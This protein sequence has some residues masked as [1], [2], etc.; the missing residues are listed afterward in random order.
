MVFHLGLLVM[1]PASQEILVPIVTNTTTTGVGVRFYYF[2]A[3]YT[4]NDRNGLQTSGMA[5]KLNGLATNGYI[6]TSSFVQAATNVNPQPIFTCPSDANYCEFKNITYIS[7]S[8][9][10]ENITENDTAIVNRDKLARYNVVLKEFF[11]YDNIT[12]GHRTF[13]KFLYSSEMLNR[14]YYDLANYTAPLNA[15]NITEVFTSKTEYEPQYRP[16]V[17]EQIFVMAYNK[18]NMYARDALNYTE[19]AFKKCYFNSTLNTVSFVDDTPYQFT[20]IY[21][22][23]LLGKHLKGN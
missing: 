16:Y 8:M 6:A 19:L 14:T 21:I 15:L 7:T 5:P 13:P 9:T 3:N 1:G 22:L 2:P 11:T 4:D 23:S 20:N 17:G 18:E 10:C 12:F